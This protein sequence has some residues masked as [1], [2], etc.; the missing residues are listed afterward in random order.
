MMQ[1]N[2]VT[3]RGLTRRAALALAA[4]AGLAGF[5]GPGRS[6]RGRAPAIRP[7]A[8][9]FEVLAEGLAFPE[10]PV[11]MPD[12]S[13]VLVELLGGRI[14]RVWDG[15][16]E[17]IS[18]IGGGP[19]GAEL[20]PDGALYIC[21]CGGAD[22]ADPHLA[23]ASQPGRIE[24]L[25]LR[26][27]KV[28]RLYDRVEGR[29]LS[30]PNDLVFDAE[31]GM[32]FTDFGKV[33]ADRF[34]R[35]GI[36]YCRPDGSHIEQVDHGDTGYN[37]IGL[38]ADGKWLYVAMNYTGRLYRMAVE[39]PG[40]LT[41]KKDGKGIAREFVGAAPG[42]RQFDGLTLTRSGN[43]C[44]GTNNDGGVTTITPAGDVTFQPVPEAMSTNLAFGGADMRDLYLTWSTGGKLVKLRW[45]EPG[46]K[47]N[48][49]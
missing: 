35:G 18:Q 31:G 13:V 15:R 3:R 48:F 46:Q 8:S 41:K 32:W 30:A 29:M 24:R 23:D 27:G 2:G 19:N 12:G 5:A 17:T 39:G 26:T 1:G 38:T 34:G 36:Y 28:D 49:T 21:N 42:D 45:D 40:K 6:L 16:K 11:I 25:D 10:G 9:K 14:T 7:M 33:L 20:G 44:I 47:L 43:I 22:P 4:G 37:G